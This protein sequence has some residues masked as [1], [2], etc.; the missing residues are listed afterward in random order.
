M[1]Y[2]DY[3]MWLCIF[4]GGTC[5]N[6]LKTLPHVIK[7]QTITPQKLSQTSTEEQKNPQKV[8]YS[9]EIDGQNR[10]LHLERNIDLIGR[11][12]S[13]VHYSSQG[14]EETTIPDYKDHCYYHGHIVEV[15]DSSASMELCS[16]IKGYVRIED[17]SY[18]IEPL[19]EESEADQQ[20][21]EGLHAVYKYEHLRRKRSSCS[22]GDNNTFFDHGSHPGGMF[23]LS[24]V[25]SSGQKKFQTGKTRTVEMVLVV[26]N[27][28][29]KKFGSR[30]I[31]EA[32]MIEVVNHMDKL[33]R[34]VGLRMMLVSLE[35]WTYTDQIQ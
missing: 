15:E 13:V 33:Y 32:R 25:K 5:V 1:Q 12:F 10:T 19:A 35:M 17:Q 2:L 4:F 31:V 20:E 30:K 24:K 14:T 7:Y 3:L 29:Y 27:T 28:E 11:H 6:S 8:T 9:L 16:G 22:H 18:L 21:G 26:D 34:A 23:Q